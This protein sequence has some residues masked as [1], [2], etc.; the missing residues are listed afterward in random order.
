MADNVSINALT[1]PARLAHY[2]HQIGRFS[3]V[4]SWVGLVHGEAREAAAQNPRAADSFVGFAVRPEGGAAEAEE[5]SLAP[6]FENKEG[7]ATTLI[8]ELDDGD[9]ESV[10]VET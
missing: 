4:P 2:C 6:S 5:V 9:P 8:E 10:H 7:A 3:G 1:R